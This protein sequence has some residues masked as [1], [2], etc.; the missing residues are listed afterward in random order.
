MTSNTTNQPA[1][2]AFSQICYD[3]I[4]EVAAAVDEGPTELDPPLYDVIDPEALERLF[5]RREIPPEDPSDHITFFYAGCLVT[6]YSNGEVEVTG[7]EETLPIS[8]EGYQQTNEDPDHTYL[9]NE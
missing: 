3:V 9:N 1:P 4:A 2:A 6:I 8:N 5:F 7:P